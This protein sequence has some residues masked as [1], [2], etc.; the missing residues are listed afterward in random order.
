MAC[1]ARK[2]HEAIVEDRRSCARAAGGSGRLHTPAARPARP[3][4]SKHCVRR[5]VRSP[6]PR[7]TIGPK[8]SKMANSSMSPAGSGVLLDAPSVVID[9]FRAIPEFAKRW[10]ARRR[11]TF[12]PLSWANATTA[13][14]APPSARSS[15]PGTSSRGRGSR[16]RCAHERSLWAH[17][18]RTAQ[19][20]RPI[21][22]ND[23]W[24]AALAWQ[25]GL[26]LAACDQ[27]FGSCRHRGPVLV[28]L[29][30]EA[31]ALLP[32]VA[33]RMHWRP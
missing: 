32:P 9:H 8:P 16:R 31:S 3:S 21:P 12:P 33:V 27:H 5:R 20:G 30:V 19:A 22:E 14:F 23:L 6:P 29:A 13:R 17:P 2:R 24:I 26:P 1:Y 4:G 25:H 10:R 7:P 15:G 11:C 18:E 28:S